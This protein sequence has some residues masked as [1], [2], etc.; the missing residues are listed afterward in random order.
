VFTNGVQ[1]RG[2]PFSTVEEFHNWLS[3]R[4]TW[5]SRQHWPAVG[6]NKIPDP[7]R[8]GLPD[9]CSIV[10]SHSDLHPSNI[11]I[12]AERPHRIVAIID[13]QQS[14]WYPDYWEFCK[15]EYTTEP[16]SEWVTEYIPQFLEEP[17]CVE[18][19][20]LYAQ[21]FGF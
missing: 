4:L 13:W 3:S 10:F 21:D 5:G 17:K 14:G 6:P 2:G 1:P 20:E 8:Q 9:N 15:A 16:R 18:A 19:F 12:S 11:L 7:Y